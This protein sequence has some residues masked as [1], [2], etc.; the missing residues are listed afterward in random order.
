MRKC[1]TKS[2]LVKADD[3]TGPVGTKAVTLTCPPVPRHT[4]D[5]SNIS[6]LK[7]NVDGNYFCQAGTG[8]G[9]EGGK[10]NYTAANISHLPSLLTISGTIPL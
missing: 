3:M 1:K 5:E 9:E 8:G 7:L 6:S 2:W 4:R 10:L